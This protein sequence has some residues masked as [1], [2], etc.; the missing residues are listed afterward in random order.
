MYRTLLQDPL[1]CEGHA[2]VVPQ[3][4]VHIL[5]EVAETV[6]QISDGVL[7]DI[8]AGPKGVWLTERR[9]RL[10]RLV[11]GFCPFG[12]HSGPS[13]VCHGRGHTVDILAGQSVDPI[14]WVIPTIADSVMGKLMGE[15]SPEMVTLRQVTHG[16]WVAP[17][18]LE[19]KAIHLAEGT[20]AHVS[21]DVMVAQDVW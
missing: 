18:S 8:V 11:S 3:Q 1:L 2:A 13:L 9:C 14:C 16:T 5:D 10:E 7:D 4:A 12:L 15:V 21:T 19:G 20:H 6:G 17:G